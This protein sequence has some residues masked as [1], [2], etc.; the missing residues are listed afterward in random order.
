M[1]DGLVWRYQAEPFGVFI[2]AALTPIAIGG[3]PWW[4]TV[5]SLAG[6]ALEVMP[7]TRWYLDLRDAGSLNL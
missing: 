7:I 6:L 1:T 4:V 5:L 2:Y 3:F